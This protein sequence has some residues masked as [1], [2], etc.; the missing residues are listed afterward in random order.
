MAVA[1]RQRLERVLKVMLD[2]RE[3]LSPYGG[4]SV[5]LPP[6]AFLLVSARR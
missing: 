2:E 6:L 3:S 5:R 1:D 4:F